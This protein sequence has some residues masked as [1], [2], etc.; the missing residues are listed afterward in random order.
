LHARSSKRGID[1][2]VV[3]KFE[4]GAAATPFDQARPKNSGVRFVRSELNLVHAYNSVP[5]MNLN[6]LF[7][8]T[9]VGVVTLAGDYLD[10][11]AHFSVLSRCMRRAVVSGD[12]CVWEPGLARPGLW[13]QR[14]SVVFLLA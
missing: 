11:F 4:T 6:I 1:T 13:T 5:F 2:R 7:E 3:L 8:Y 12:L 9:L 10:K 14:T